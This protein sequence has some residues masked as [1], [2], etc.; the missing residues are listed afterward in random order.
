MKW[1]GLRPDIDPLAGSVTSDVRFAG[2]SLADRAALEIA[3]RLAAVR[4][5]TV[6]VVCVGP[7]E[8]DRMLRDALA[9][10]ATAAQRIDH[11]LDGTQQPTSAAVAAALSAACNGA[12]MVLC[13]D[14]SLDRGSGSVPPMLAMSLGLDQACGLV[15]VDIQAD[16][17]TVERRLDG[18]RREVLRVTGPAVLSV[19]GSAASLRRASIAGVLAAKQATIEVVHSALPT[20]TIGVRVERVEAHRPPPRHLHTN[21]SSD[22]R[23]RVSA[24]LGVGV[25]RTP[26]L[27]M[28]LEPDAAADVIIERLVAWGQIPS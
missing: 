22:P 3:L 20:T 9:V 21:D 10:G 23:D 25:Q 24:L 16:A 6:R 28:A 11:G 8:A 2:A 17:V 27:R 4:H 1:V 12:A 7:P 5:T 13:G 18:G 26:P 19:E 15:A 14:W